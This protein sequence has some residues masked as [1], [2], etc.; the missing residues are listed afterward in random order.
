VKD[1]EATV[2]PMSSPAPTKPHDAWLKQCALDFALTAL[3]QVLAVVLADCA[4]PG[5]DIARVG[6]DDLAKDMGQ[7]S[8]LLAEAFAHL[9]ARGHLRSV[10]RRDGSSAYQFVQRAR[11]ITRRARAALPPAEVVL[12][13]PASQRG[14]V[15]E[16]VG[17][18]LVRPQ[19][20]AEAW[21]QA[22][23]LRQQ[24]TL[25]R[26]GFSAPVVSREIQ[27]LEGVVRRALWRAVL[28]PD[29]PA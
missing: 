16:I 27:T 26:K 3:A 1:S 19:Q 4:D 9:V 14:L 15:R 2:D 23:L 6:P 7:P 29:E 24:R 18:M 20:A 22:E 17:E 28:S 10:P 13:P 21:L 25:R 8:S 12:F 11:P 5:R